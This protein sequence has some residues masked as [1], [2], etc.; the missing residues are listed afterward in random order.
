MIQGQ[1]LTASSVFS[2]MAVF[3][4][5]RDTLFSTFYFIPVIINGTYAHRYSAVFSYLT[6]TLTS[7]SF[8]GQNK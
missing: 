7:Q 1:V 5:M 6:I 2:S 8:V 4:L 3:D